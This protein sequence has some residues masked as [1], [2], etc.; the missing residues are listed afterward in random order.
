MNWTTFGSRQ[1][2]LKFFPSFRWNID[3]FLNHF[4]VEVSEAQSLND[5]AF[6][7]AGATGRV[8]NSILVVP[9][10]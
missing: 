3:P 10:I 5:F 2:F 1:H 8:I 9:N 6:L 7:G 4:E